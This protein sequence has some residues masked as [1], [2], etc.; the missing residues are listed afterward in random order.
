MAEFGRE[1]IEG[2]ASVLGREDPGECSQKGPA[3]AVQDNLSRGTGRVVGVE[4]M[5]ISCSRTRGVLRV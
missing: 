1:I 2:E 5:V 3:L 4:D